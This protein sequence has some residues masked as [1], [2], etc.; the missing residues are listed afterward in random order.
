M[1][2]DGYIVLR[3]FIDREQVLKARQQVIASLAER[4]LLDP[5]SPADDAVAAKGKEIGNLPDADKFP[6]VGEVIHGDTL[7]EFFDG[8]LGGQSRH[9][10][11]IWIRVK[12][13]GQATAPHCDS[14]YMGR[15]TTNLFTTW[16]PLGDV[17]KELGALMVLEKSHEIEKLKAHYAKMDIDRDGNWKKWRFRH[18]GFFRGGQ[19]S[20]NPKGVQREFKRRWLSTDFRAG[21]VAIFTTVTMHGTLDNRTERIRISTDS[22]FQLASDPAD[23]RW[24]G[25]KPT[26]HAK[27][28]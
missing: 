21:D 22:R 23:E 7:N 24:V 27:S 10:D 12:G 16:A 20:K 8:F 1:A 4:D 13:P 25:D 3:D 6:S 15:G 17:P 19:Y 2:E 26:G 14:V 5:G 28:Y 18:G 9:L 11:H